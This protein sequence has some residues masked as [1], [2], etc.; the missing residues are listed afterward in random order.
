[1]ACASST[2]VGVAE[3]RVASGTTPAFAHH[4]WYPRETSKT[5]DE[6]AP[7]SRAARAGRLPPAARIAS[8]NKVTIR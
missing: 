8:S 2:S 4:S 7:W 5:Y 1:M 3:R 6:S